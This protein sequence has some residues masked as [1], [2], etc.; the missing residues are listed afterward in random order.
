M[1]IT[2]LGLDSALDLV[3]TEASSTDVHM[4]RR[5]VDDSLHTLHIGLPH[6]VRTSMG[7]RNLDTKRNTL[8]AN[9]TLSH[10]TNTSLSAAYIS[11]HT[12]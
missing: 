10:T 9:I 3:G 6:T 8:A 1:V 7:V 12:G 11:K 4:A 2:R 5:T